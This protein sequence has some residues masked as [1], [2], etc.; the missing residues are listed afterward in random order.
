VNTKKKY[1]FNKNLNLKKP[2]KRQR[3]K[4]K[5]WNVFITKRH[6]CCS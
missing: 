1:F 2:I 6:K 5:F 3:T 4:Q